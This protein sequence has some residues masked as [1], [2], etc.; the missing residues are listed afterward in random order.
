[1][2]EWQSLMYIY[3]CNVYILSDIAEQKPMPGP[4]FF[5]SP[6]PEAPPSASVIAQAL[7][8]SVSPS[9]TP[10]LSSLAGQPTP[11]ISAGLT[12]TG[13]TGKLYL[14]YYL[15]FDVTKHCYG[16]VLDPG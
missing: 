4:G 6:K 14:K 12:S 8:K 11:S 15:C 3:M 16:C 10:A 1:M 7:A 2:N 13:G 9:V 5:S